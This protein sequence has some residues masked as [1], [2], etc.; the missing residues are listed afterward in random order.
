M[1]I[2]II[3][4]NINLDFVG[5]RKLAYSFSGILLLLSILSLVVR[6]PNYGVDFAGGSIVQVRF[7]GAVA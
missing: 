2:E 4:S 7:A 3:K 1:S 5:K 6:G